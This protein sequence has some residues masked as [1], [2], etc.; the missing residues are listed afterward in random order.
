METEFKVFKGSYDSLEEDIKEYQEKFN[1]EVR[2]VILI[3]HNDTKTIIGVI[4]EKRSIEDEELEELEER[5]LG[6]RE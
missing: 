4:F 3:K 1:I 2:N 6:F 5:I